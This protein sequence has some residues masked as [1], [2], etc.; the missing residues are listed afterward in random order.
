EGL[1]PFGHFPCL[2]DE[3]RS[4]LPLEL[5][6]ALSQS[7]LFRLEL[8]LFVLELS[9]LLIQ[10]EELVQDRVHVDSL[11]FGSP[12]HGFGVFADSFRVEHGGLSSQNP[13]QKNRERILPAK[14]LLVSSDS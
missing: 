7:S 3:L 9:P 8:I 12:S 13:F 4:L 14:G 5:R 2:A 10:L 1:Q 11:F 6:D